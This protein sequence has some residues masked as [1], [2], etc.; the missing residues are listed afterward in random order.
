MESLRNTY[1]MIY[2]Y[3]DLDRGKEVAAKSLLEFSNRESYLEW[4]T[5]WKL[6]YKQLSERQTELRK[7]L[8]QPHQL[9]SYDGFLFPT[10]ASS[11]MRERWG[12]KQILQM[13]LTA[14]RLGKEKS[15]ELKRLVSS[16]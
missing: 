8:S 16:N 13:M 9:E 12:N 7:L 1:R 2:H 6:A 10:N 11:W 14:R 5:E 3:A 4:R 15:C